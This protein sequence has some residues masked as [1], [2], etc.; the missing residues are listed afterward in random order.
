MLFKLS[1]ILKVADI[2]KLQ[3]SLFV[4]DYMHNK[5]PISFNDSFTKT[6]NPYS[7]QSSNVFSAQTTDQIFISISKT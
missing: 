5:L 1:E 2:Y 7:R 3:C 6:A 4:H